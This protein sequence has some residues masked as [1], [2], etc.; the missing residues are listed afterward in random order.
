MYVCMISNNIYSV[1]MQSNFLRRWLGNANVQ[2]KPGVS[3]LMY[4]HNHSKPS[5]PGASL[6]S[7]INNAKKI[8]PFLQSALCDSCEE[9]EAR[10]QVKH[11]FYAKG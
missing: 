6:H 8:M 4:L 11:S 3:G 2:C 9:L 10:Y 1:A 7:P 5:A